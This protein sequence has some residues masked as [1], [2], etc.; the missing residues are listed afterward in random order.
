MF[1]QTFFIW[2]VLKPMYINKE[3]KVKVRTT[4]AT[5]VPNTTNIPNTTNTTNIPN[6]PN[7]PQYARKIIT[8]GSI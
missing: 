3:E 7:I 1:R 5:N 2:L 4:K 6:I 8:M